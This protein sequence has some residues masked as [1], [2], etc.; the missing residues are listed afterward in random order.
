MA[1]GLMSL[2]N[3]TLEANSAKAGWGDSI[4]MFDGR[5]TKANEDVTLFPNTPR[6]WTGAAP[7]RWS[8]ECFLFAK[9]LHLL[10]P[11]HPPVG[12]TMKFS[13]G[14]GLE[15]WLPPDSF[16]ADPTPASNGSVMP[17]FF[18]RVPQLPNGLPQP[19]VPGVHGGGGWNRSTSQLLHGP[20]T[21]TGV[22]WHQGEANTAPSACEVPDGDWLKA[23][24]KTE[25][26]SS[27]TAGAD[28]GEMGY[29]VA[30]NE[31]KGAVWYAKQFPAMVQSYR[32]HFQNPK[33][34]FVWVNLQAY[35]DGHTGIAGGKWCKTKH[36]CWKDCAT[37]GV[38]G[39]LGE[40]NGT[41]I[42]A[43]RAAQSRTLSLPHTAEALAFDMV[44]P[45][46]GVHPHD[47][48]SEL[49]RR[50]AKA[51]IL[52][53]LRD[54]NQPI[55][56]DMRGWETPTLVSHS[57]SADAVHL[58]FGKCC[59]DTTTLHLGPAMHCDNVSTVISS[60]K[61]NYAAGSPFHKTKQR[62]CEWSPFEIIAATGERVRPTAQIMGTNVTL[63]LPP[64]FHVAEIRYAYQDIVLCGLYLSAGG[65]AS[66]AT[67]G[68]TGNASLAMP[69][70]PF[71]VRVTHGPTPPAPPAPPA[72]PPVPMDFG[73]K[74][75][76]AGMELVSTWAI[77]SANQWAWNV[78]EQSFHLLA[79]P[80]LCLTASEAYGSKRNLLLQNCRPSNLMQRFER[81][82]D[83]NVST[84]IYGKF[85][86]EYVRLAGNRQTPDGDLGWCLARSSKN[87]GDL[88]SAILTPCVSAT[89]T[90]YPK[91]AGFSNIPCVT[92]EAC[93]LPD[94]SWSQMWIMDNTTGF[95]H[96]HSDTFV[97]G[98]CPV[99]KI[100]CTEE[101]H[102]SLNGVCDV[103]SGRCACDSGWKGSQCATLDLLP[104]APL[105]E[106]AG[107]Q[108]VDGGFNTSSWG[109]AVVRD[110]EGSYHMYNA[111]FVH[112]TPVGMWK[113]ASRVTHA[114]AVLSGEVG[115]IGE[116]KRA[117]GA[118]G[119]VSR[120]MC[121]EQPETQGVWAHAPDARR[122]P[123]GEYVVW[124]EQHDCNW[125]VADWT[126]PFNQSKNSKGGQNWG[127]SFR[128][129]F[130][131]TMMVYSDS[132]DGPWSE[133]V[134]VLGSY[135]FMNNSLMDPRGQDPDKVLSATILKNG[136]AVGL[137]RSLFNLLDPDP[138]SRGGFMVQV[139]HIVRA[140]NWKNASDWTADVVTRNPAWGAGGADNPGGLMFPY[141]THRGLQDPF[142]WADAKGRF[143][144]LAQ[145]L[146]STTSVHS[147]SDD[148]NAE[149]WHFGGVCFSNTVEGVGT[150]ARR[151]RPHLIFGLDGTTPIALTN[152]VTHL[153]MPAIPERGEPDPRVDWFRSFT[154]LQPIN[155]SLKSDDDGALTRNSFA[156]HTS[157]YA[158]NESVW[159]M[160]PWVGRAQRAVRC[161]A[162]QSRS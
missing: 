99:S 107:Y 73:C 87:I 105:R 116:Y 162:R 59:G 18:G 145:F 120:G 67:V 57:V 123:T 158:A 88:G 35:N 63:P 154:L 48:K 152:G 136:S 53:D 110:D 52:M 65:N 60:E 1:F 132:P 49:G 91:Q 148:P 64:D 8:A 4:R 17:Y 5:W 125:T 42:A 101:W 137:F 9:H 135:D 117:A 44:D 41:S 151:E 97:L 10:D 50:L 90:C 142:I 43:L 98:A 121:P 161:L 26:L 143:H 75:P 16:V 115:A 153:G 86:S 54:R 3:G 100:A 15:Y 147:F 82:A 27:P 78:G 102:C 28:G 131:P 106:R 47:S 66:S 139:E 13:G 7:L 81:N 23:L 118:A 144:Q 56:S 30:I 80:S 40:W 112:H 96:S 157:S 34:K 79:E 14:T 31:P 95:L 69:A 92:G 134:N 25:C 85:P 103:S 150:M 20:T 122:A 61:F 83:V 155:V 114:K 129:N 22:L 32:A 156:F 140:R 159:P 58:S 126:P 68:A 133:P 141:L 19:G 89:Q 29:S 113:D 74:N 2:A 119:V 12:L 128:D 77:G 72:P 111:E 149:T 36:D 46:N 21:L 160:Y 11:Q 33:M 93:C 55:P 108:Q 76:Q 51:A 38:C 84:A 6:N 45:E 130:A 39:T 109:G 127:R 138:T 124:Y 146:D 71:R 94:F 104:A 70:R 62:C 24:S 37:K